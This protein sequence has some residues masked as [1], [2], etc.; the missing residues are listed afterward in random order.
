[1]PKFNIFKTD[2]WTLLKQ[3]TEGIGNTTISDLETEIE[4]L[5]ESNDFLFK[6]NMLLESVNEKVGDV[7]IQKHIDNSEIS[8]EKERINRE[9]NKLSKKNVELAN[10]LGETNDDLD[11]SD[12][13]EITQ[14]NLIENNKIKLNRYIKSI[15]S[16]ESEK[17]TLNDKIDK[18]NSEHDEILNKSKEK[19]TRKSTKI[20]TMTEDL[21]T[22]EAQISKLKFRLENKSE[23]IKIINENIE[24]VLVIIEKELIPTAYK[25]GSIDS[26]ENLTQSSITRFL[27]P[28]A[29]EMSS[30]IKIKDMVD[31]F[32]F[33]KNTNTNS[34]TKLFGGN[35]TSSKLAKKL[36]NIDESVGKTNLLSKVY[37]GPDV[38]DPHQKLIDQILKHSEIDSL[39]HEDGGYFFDSRDRKSVV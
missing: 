32:K 1:M 5:Q 26:I 38:I 13:S 4:S 35:I 36:I 39:F 2:I 23:E 10:E 34:I 17:K 28:N 29:T 20:K 9:K 19:N 14:A 11:L 30:G 27:N 16:L 33:V 37:A 8:A 12:L 18:L 15:S 31:D 22:K 6:Q 24:K 3:Q 25:R 21:S 7:N